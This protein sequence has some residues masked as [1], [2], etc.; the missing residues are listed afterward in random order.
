MTEITFEESIDAM[1]AQ[2]FLDNNSDTEIVEWINHYGK[3]CDEVISGIYKYKTTDMYWMNE[4]QKNAYGEMPK[5]VRD[6]ITINLQD[7]TIY[8]SEPVSSQFML[9]LCNRNIPKRIKLVELLRQ[10]KKN[11]GALL[12]WK[13]AN[14][15]DGSYW[16]SLNDFDKK[17]AKTTFINL[18]KLT[19]D[20][21]GHI[22]YVNKFSPPYWKYITSEWLSD[23]GLYF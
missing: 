21:N 10:V 6:S 4:N 18:A 15:L 9:K 2:Q 1:I 23:S 14:N 19:I 8:S 11:G 16:K 22:Y 13:I 12:L 17:L 5:E 20:I 3:Y 7:A